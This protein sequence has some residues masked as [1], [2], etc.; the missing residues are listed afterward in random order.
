MEK[1]PLKSYK[2]LVTFLSRFQVEPGRKVSLSGPGS[3][4]WDPGW[5]GDKSQS[6]EER[7]KVAEQILSESITALVNAQDRLYAGDSWSVLIVFQA[8]DAAGKDSTIKHVM[9]GLNPQGCQVTSFKQPS[10]EELDHNFLWRY[11]KGLPQRGCFGIF[12][13][14]YYEEVLVVR[15]HPQLIKKQR[16][17]AVHLSKKLWAE[18]FEDINNYEKHL[19]R[20][21]TLVLKF[22][23]N[24]SKAE[25]RKRFI[26]RLENKEKQWK[27]SE[28]D[29]EESRY[30][31][32]YTGAYEEAISATSTKWAPWH[33]I[34]ADH[35][36]V[37]RALV[38][39]II[40]KSIR[41]L[42]LKFPKV[43]KAGRKKLEEQL[44]MLNEE[45]KK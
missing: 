36:W 3:G 25:Q 8:R 31:D 41:D 6:K 38:A 35:K 20:N 11:N 16:I 44:R 18:R 39:G 26:D 30:W 14:S 21:G 5:A 43:D 42:N 37:T 17:P 13:R 12:N 32:D 24:V 34:P 33:I 28:L 10:S 9:S 4:R 22:F 40:S 1:K 27:Y 7:K 23:L 29:L 45:S 19:A 2:Q 15:V